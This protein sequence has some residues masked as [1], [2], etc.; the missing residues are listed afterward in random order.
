MRKLRSLLMI[1]AWAIF[2]STVGYSADLNFSNAIF[3]SYS[4]KTDFRLSINTYEDVDEIVKVGA[5]VLSGSDLVISKQMLDRFKDPIPL[6]DAAKFFDKLNKNKGMIILKNKSYKE[7]LSEN[8]YLEAGRYFKDDLGKKQWRDKH[9]KPFGFRYF[10][11]QNSQPHSERFYFCLKKGFE[12]CPPFKL[13]DLSANA[14]GTELVGLDKE[15]KKR[16]KKFKGLLKKDSG[17]FFDLIFQDR[18][19]PIITGC[20]DGQFPELGKVKPATTGDW[21]RIDGL[22]IADNSGNVSGTCLCLGKIDN[23]PST[24]EWGKNFSTEWIVEEERPCPG[25]VVDN[26]VILP[27]TVHGA[28]EY[29]V[30]AWD[31]SNNL[32]PGDP[33]I[34]END[35]ENCYGLSGTSAKNLGRDPLTAEDWPIKKLGQIDPKER[36]GKGYIRIEDNDFPNMLIKIE[37]TKDGQCIY[38]PPLP[39]SPEK[40]PVFTSKRLGPGTPNLDI[41]KNFIG[42][43]TSPGSSISFSK[44]MA[45]VIVSPGVISNLTKLPFVIYDVIFPDNDKSYYI[46]PQERGLAEKWKRNKD[47]G[48]IKSQFRLEDFIESDHTT[49]GEK[50]TFDPKTFGKRHGFGKHITAHWHAGLQEDVEY[51][52]SLW[53]DDNIKWATADE[54]GDIKESIIEIPSGIVKGEIKVEIPGQ[55]SKSPRSASMGGKNCISNEVRVVFREP[56]VDK[57]RRFKKNISSL[58]D[59]SDNK[60]PY[61][62]ASVKDFAG[63][64]RSMRLYLSVSDEKSTIRV[65]EHKHGKNR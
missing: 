65:I 2:L 44:A 12:Y 5:S 4:K 21:Y 30:F 23:Y 47:V 55:P 58:K 53:G 9:F 48:F 52:I 36:R 35:P 25:G 13:S 64:T 16:K 40:L 49:N 22:S 54:F 61:I 29:S 6:T 42:L 43:K 39:A 60:F 63:H 17:V 34:R 8:F 31:Q 27:N 50:I 1:V 45:V 51:K 37:S 28:M 33:N 32:N 3:N 7:F 46:S 26:Y 18:T 10:D 24:K 59:L 14:S 38:F 56:T 15:I 19:P 11:N 57:D 62:E 20:V 41:Y